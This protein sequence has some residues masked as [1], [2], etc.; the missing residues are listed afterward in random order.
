MV[1]KKAEIGILEKEKRVFTELTYLTRMG[2]VGAPPSLV[3]D[4]TS[5]VLRWRPKLCRI[6]DLS[7]N[8]EE[9]NVQK[10]DPIQPFRILIVGNYLININEEKNVEFEEKLG[11]QSL[12]D[13]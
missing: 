7:R 8:D 1:G 5:P 9:K 2:A 3:H 4:W 13:L 12:L 6:M 11:F 10:F